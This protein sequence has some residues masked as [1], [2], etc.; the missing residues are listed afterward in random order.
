MRIGTWNTNFWKKRW[1]EPAQEKD[2]NDIINWT[3]DCGSI[4]KKYDFDFL[5]L[6]EAIPHFY[7]DFSEYKIYF[8]PIINEIY[9]NPSYFNSSKLKQY[10]NSETNVFLQDSCP[11]KEINNTLLRPFEKWW[12]NA[13]LSRKE[14]ILCQ[15]YV[16]K[17]IYP[18]SSGLMCYIFNC[19]TIDNPKFICLINIYG[20]KDIT[21]IKDDNRKNKPYYH[22]TIH[23]ILSDV[24]PIIEKH[25]DMQIILGGDFNVNEGDDETIFTR[26]KKI[27]LI[28]CSEK[29]ITYYPTRYGQGRQ[30]DYIF[31]NR[32]LSCACENLYDGYIENVSDHAM[33]ILNI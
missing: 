22:T 33:L 10:Y 24:E 5:L 14:Y 32:K 9:D 20:K 4:I 7:N 3:N 31:S 16:F 19:S 26:I 27:G 1:N 12:G 15:Y 8:R 28:N 13:I 30:N 2:K 23:R 29:E 17:S 21:D 6:Q 11:M 25:N 18:G